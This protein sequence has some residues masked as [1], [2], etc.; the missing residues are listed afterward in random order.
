VI[1]RLQLQDA[2]SAN[3]FLLRAL[4]QCFFCFIMPAAAEVDLDLPFML[5]CGVGRHDSCCMSRRLA[6]WGLGVLDKLTEMYRLAFLMK[7][8]LVLGGLS[9]VK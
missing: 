4:G 8:D 1:G 6:T 2:L 7:V 3:R 9:E 5:W